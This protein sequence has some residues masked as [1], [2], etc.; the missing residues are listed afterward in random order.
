MT[1]ETV[2]RII[3]KTELTQMISLARSTI[4]DKLNAKSARHD[5]SFPRAIKLG[6]SAIGWRQSEVNQWIATRS[7]SSQTMEVK[8]ESTQSH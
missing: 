2:D 7:Q 3:R 6:K 8:N 4:Y 5:P 1:L